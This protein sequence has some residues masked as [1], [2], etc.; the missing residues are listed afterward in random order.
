MQI[1]HLTSIRWLGI[2]YAPHPAERTFLDRAQ[3][4]KNGDLTVTVAVLG[5]RE[6]DRFFGVPLARRGIQPVWLEIVNH[7]NGPLFIDP[8]RLDPNYYPPLEAALVNHFAV[9]RRLAGFGLLGWLFLPLLVLLPF[10]YFGAR[11]ANLSMDEYF[12]EHA[13]PLGSIAPGESAS[14]FVFT[15]LDDGNKI[16]RVR[17]LSDSALHEFVFSVPVPGLDMDYHRQPFEDIL[18]NVARIECDEAALRDHLQ[19][20]PRTTTNRR[21]TR[22]G[23]PANLVIVGDFGTILTAF[24]ER[25]DETETISVATSWK[26]AKAFL[27]GSLYRYSP[28]SPL[29]LYGRSQDFALQRVRRRINE[30]LHLRLWLT[31]LSYEGKPV[32][33]GQVSRDIGVRL[34]PRT[35]NLTTHRIDPDVDEARNYVAADLLASGHLDRVGFVDGVGLSERAAPK[36]N[37]TGDPFVTDGLRIVLILTRESTSTKFLGWQKQGVGDVF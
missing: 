23:D 8:V 27:L 10:K 7:R 37:L 26:T 2:F 18:S 24:G 15:T 16:V 35:W 12:R 1:K 20:Q 22:E 29:F 3:I 33:I 6:S 14:G 32:W 13:F 9:G 28:V 21:A 36:H 34:T 4:Q 25:W 19:Q 17:G 5:S 31:N 11:R 30:R